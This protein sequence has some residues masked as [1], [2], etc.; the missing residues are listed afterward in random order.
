MN[1]RGVLN[2]VKLAVR[3]MRKVGGGDEGGRGGSIVITSSATV[4][5]PEQ[6]LPMYSASKLA[7]CFPPPSNP[8]SRPI[9][10]CVCVGGGGSFTTI[11]HRSDPRPPLYTPCR[12]HH[13]QC[14]RSCRDHHESLSPELSR[15]AHSYR[16][17]CWFTDMVA[18]AV[19]FS[20]VGMQGRRV[21]AYGKDD[22]VKA[23]GRWNG[24]TILA[25]GESYTEVE[26]IIAELRPKRFGEENAKLT[27]LQQADT[28]FRA[29]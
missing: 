27:R 23:E 19:M 25:L 24:R 7:V 20:V 1:L 26:E 29:M 28:D 12:R 3:A 8:L 16:I 2:F 6:S 10:V 14:R 18:R 9:C 5:A 11:A 4:Y 22:G 17:T 21:E 15:A 13:H